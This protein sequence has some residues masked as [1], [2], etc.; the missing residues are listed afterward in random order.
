MFCVWYA[1]WG[2]SWM[3]GCGAVDEDRGLGPASSAGHRR[4]EGGLCGMG[5]RALTLTLSRGER[6]SEGRVRGMRVCRMGRWLVDRL[7]GEVVA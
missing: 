5:R 3:R 6:G 2:R 4:G 7:V 1:G